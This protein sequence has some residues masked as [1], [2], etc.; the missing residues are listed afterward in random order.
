[1]RDDRGLRHVSLT[2]EDRA[3]ADASTTDAM[4]SPWQLLAGR[5]A[6]HAGRNFVDLYVE[7]RLEVSWQLGGGRTISR[8]TLHQ[9][10]V[11]VRR[12]GALYSSDG[13]ERVVVADLLSLPVRTLPALPLA[14]FPQPPEALPE[15]TRVDREPRTL[16]YIWRWSAVVAPGRVAFPKRPVLWELTFADGGRLVTTAPPG[17]GSCTAAA[18]TEGVTA[19]RTGPSV[20]LLAPQ[21]AAT[22]VHELFGHGLEGDL[23]QQGTSPWRDRLGERVTSVG[24]TVVDDP[25]RADLPGAFDTDDTGSPATSRV[26]VANGEIVAFLGRLGIESAS[27]PHPG[28]ER[29]A[30]V[31]TP[32]RPR[33]SNLITTVVGQPPEVPREEADLEVLSVSSGLL[34]PR[35]GVVMLQARAAY[36]LR[37]GRRMRAL[38]PFTLV[39]SAASVCRGLLAAGGRRAI[40]T[41]PGW[42][43]KDGEVVPVAG[44]APSLLLEGLDVR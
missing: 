42:C 14:P 20:V 5:L 6:G 13:A 23:L 15:L 10:G 19:P 37:H 44:E 18:P 43:G 2:A 7:R 28:N 33:V 38:A 32:P 34:E 16:R 12:D 41:E 39:G 8:Q 22:L 30:T 11:G 25:C 1:M 29:R 24:L 3:G 31:H 17:A 26:L 4:A 35:S 40:V 21:P 27:S 9:D 36:S